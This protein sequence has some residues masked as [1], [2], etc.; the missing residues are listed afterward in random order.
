LS[1]PPPNEAIRELADVL[2]DEA[3]REVVRLFLDDFPA[4]I[5]KL[6]TGS[7][8]EQVM[9]AHGLKS[10][11]LHMGALGLSRRMAELEARLG[12]PGETVSEAELAGA[13]AD[14]EAVAP[15]LRQYA[16]V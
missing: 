13:M 11:A 3:T 2:G 12:K 16:G 10:S 5:G 6:G 7:R 14:F 4:S 8:E 15:L 9:T 1:L